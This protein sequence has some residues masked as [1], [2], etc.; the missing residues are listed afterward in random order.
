MGHD[1]KLNG[2]LAL[3]ND[4]TIGIDGDLPWP[5]CGEDLARFKRVTLYS[6]LIMGRKTA[7]SLPGP[8]PDRNNLVLSRT[9]ESGNG[10]SVFR[11]KEDVL[12]AIDSGKPAWIIGGGEIFN[13][14]AK[15][16]STWY[17]TRFLEKFDG[18]NKVSVKL[19]ELLTQDDFIFRLMSWEKAKTFRGYFSILQRESK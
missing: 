16:I 17:L 13:L 19:S 8:L 7:E 6:N 11:T 12:S 9:M 15:D 4:N 18:E 10:F 14:F 5:K 1:F 3:D 2:M